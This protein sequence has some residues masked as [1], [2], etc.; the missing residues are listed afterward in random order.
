MEIYQINDVSFT[1]P[2]REKAALCHLDLTIE[3]GSFV[4]LCG[5]SGCGKTTLLRLLKP[6]LSP[7]GE[8][9]GQILFAGAPIDE[10]DAR[11]AA[12]KI[13][14]VLQ[15]I[16]NQLVTDKVWHEL[17]FGLESLGVPTPEIRTR[18][19]EMASFF[20]IGDWFHKKVSDLSGGQKQLLNLASVMVMQPQVLILDEPTAQLDPIAAGEFLQTLKKIN[21][22]FGTTILLSEHRLE[23]VIPLA[24]RIVVME[25]GGI[26][27]SGE[28]RDIGGKLKAL[29][30][31]MYD[32]LPTPMRVFEELDGEGNA[33]V[34]VGEG[35]LWLERFAKSHPLCPDAIPL[36]PSPIGGQDCLTLEEVWFR[37]DKEQEDVIRGCS[38]QVKQGEIFSILGGNGS[39]KTTLLSLLA[40]LRIP[41]R[42]K[43]WKD[44]DQ[45]VGV[46]P[47]NPQVLFDQKTAFLDLMDA[48]SDRPLTEEEKEVR[49]LELAQLCRLSGLLTAHPY[50]LSG[51][52]Q[53]RLAL[54]KVL[55]REPKIL[56]LDEP[57]KGFDS[58]FKEVF[59]EILFAC[60]AEGRTVMLVSHDIEFCAEVS[61]RCGLFFDGTLMTIAHPRAFFAGNRFYT[62]GANRMARDLLPDAILAEDILAACGKKIENKPSC[63]PS[64]ATEVPVRRE[65]KKVLP[66]RK[67]TGILFGLLFV[68]LCA[69]QLA[70]ISWIPAKWLHLASGL[71]LG[72]SLFCF[73]PHRALEQ[74]VTPVARRKLSKRT[75]LSAWLLLLAVPLTILFGMYYLGDRKYYVVSLLIILETLIPFMMAFEDRKPLAR[76]LVLLSVLCAIAVCGRMAFFA[77]SQF[78]PVLAILILVSICLGGECGFLAGA[79]VGFVSNFFFGQGPWTPWQMFAFGMVGFLAGVLFQKGLLRKTRVSLC[80]FG[81]LA[82]VLVYGGLSNAS[83]VLLMQPKPTL[84]MFLAAFGAGLPFDLIHGASTVFFLWFLAEP[85]IEKLE[86]IKQKYGLTE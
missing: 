11:G 84:E 1:Y 6:T 71:L 43:V 14:F 53:Q 32:A 36:V 4:C 28:P 50:D 51:G 67:M 55:L 75:T 65:E 10:L 73:F 59:K 45:A 18:V 44:C 54:C 86:R 8:R 37:Y 52:E 19:A 13:G 22:E 74:T 60:K 48:L 16:E 85:M 68:V 29:G 35:R 34:T 47:Q 57:T 17:A 25:D 49:V 69:L 76:E 27:V 78:K 61:D 3:E 83:M 80:I 40:G 41:Q 30:H 56:L 79:A 9:A 38:L 21:R 15:N 24:D 39:G 72:A 42:G 20:G 33:P 31:K 77:L 81:F 46:L 63:I 62:T 7:H 70:E 2:E 26:L 12:E 64:M 66:R 82:T 58:G 5:R 23:E